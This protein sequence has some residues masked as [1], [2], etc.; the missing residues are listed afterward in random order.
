MGAASADSRLAERFAAEWTTLDAAAFALEPL[1]RAFAETAAAAGERRK[2]LE[3]VRKAGEQQAAAVRELLEG[4]PFADAGALRAAR[5][6][7]AEARRIEALETKLAARG[8]EMEGRFHHVREQIRA[9]REG[10]A[11]EGEALAALEQ[12]RQALAGRITA[13]AEARTTLR[14]DLERDEETRRSHTAELAQLESEAR[15]LA[16]WVQLRRLIGSANGAAFRQFAQ[17]LS[18]DLLVRHAN[19]HLARLS[20]RYR[21]RRVEGELSLEIIDHH[22]ADA[23]RPM[24]SLS[25]GESFL[26][27]LALALGL[28]DLAGR[29][30]RIDSLFIDEG[31]GSLDA[32]TL[33]LA[34]AAL[35]AL[36]LHNKT[37]GVISHVELLKERIPVQIRV[38]KRTGGLSV[39]CLPE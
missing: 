26:A 6:D 39:L 1:R 38:E 11:P 21:L 10:S 33:D 18:L 30:V 13:A 16:V 35:D 32:D 5:L 2:T 7:A 25:G 19:R 17:G 37:V 22:Q 3:G 27:S 31:F 29:N 36:R 4:T 15:G 34:V 23:T 8:Q 24:E 20:D 9:L 14:N 28:S 12:E